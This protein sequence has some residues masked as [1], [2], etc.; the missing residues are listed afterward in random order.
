MHGV[1]TTLDIKPLDDEGA[2]LQDSL[3][4]DACDV[5][6]N[7]WFAG[8]IEHVGVCARDLYNS[9][10]EVPASAPDSAMQLRMPNGNFLLV[11]T[12]HEDDLDH[13]EIEL[14]EAATRSP[15]S[16]LEEPDDDGALLVHR[17][18]RFEVYRWY[19]QA[20]RVSQMSLARDWVV[21]T[22]MES[23]T[24]EVCEIES[25][26]LHQGRGGEFTDDPDRWQLT[27]LEPGTCEV[28]LQV[29]GASQTHETELSF[30]WRLSADAAALGR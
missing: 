26:R 6:D 21:S 15:Q 29:E 17:G 9:K 14:V 2:S 7:V 22:N 4:W 19:S 30:R 1:P 20:R 24:P 5:V 25:G 23:R 12:I 10:I 27:L 13:L 28:T 16:I 18:Y 11:D 8:E 3:N